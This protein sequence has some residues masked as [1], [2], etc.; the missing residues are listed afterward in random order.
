MK[1]KR[2]VAILSV[3]LL[4][5]F[6]FPVFDW[7]HFE[8]SGLNYVLSTHI[9]AYKY[10]LL[11]VPFS[12]LFLFLGALYNELYFFN[13]KML[14]WLPLVSLLLISLMRYKNWNSKNSF[15]GNENAF[16]TIDIGFWLILF[17]SVLVIVVCRESK[18]LYH[19][20][21]SSDSFE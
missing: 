16:S 20:E 9:S 10:F 19:Y 8:M 18:L 21:K 11:L 5:S 1:R 13:S 6:F 12:A 17:F 4:A 3:A 7:H 14:S 2:S 15:S